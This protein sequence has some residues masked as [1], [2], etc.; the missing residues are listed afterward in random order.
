MTRKLN[1]DLR[2]KLI[3]LEHYTV[4]LRDLNTKLLGGNMCRAPN[5]CIGGEW[6]GENGQRKKLVELFNVRE[7]MIFLNN[8]LHR[9]TNWI[10]HIIRRRYLLYDVIEGQR[11]EIVVVGRRGM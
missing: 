10:G 5:C 6:R 4:R 7:K 1:T 3:C 2:K 11:T 9:K 8:I